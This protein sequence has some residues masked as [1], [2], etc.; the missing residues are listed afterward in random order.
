[1][2][3]G[4]GRTATNIINKHLAVL[5]CTVRC[6]RLTDSQ[7]HSPVSLH[8]AAGGNDESFGMNE[9]NECISPTRML[10]QKKIADSDFL[11]FHPLE[12]SSIKVLI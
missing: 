10:N 1:M 5:Y 9:L 7:S 3:V 2:P 11:F 8:S 4:V 12:I 6:H